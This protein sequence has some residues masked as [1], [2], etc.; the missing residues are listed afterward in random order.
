MKAPRSK[1]LNRGSSLFAGGSLCWKSKGV[2][3]ET[4]FVIRVIR[5]KSGFIRYVSRITNP[6]SRLMAIFSRLQTSHRYAKK[7]CLLN[8]V[9]E[10]KNA[11]SAKCYCRVGSDSDGGLF[12]VSRSPFGPASSVN[13]E[14]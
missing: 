14:S 1:P 5:L 10:R 3:R 9:S 7:A 12:A 2:K 11:A 6:F 8:E 4:S 13:A